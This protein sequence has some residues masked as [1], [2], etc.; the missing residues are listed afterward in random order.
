MPR[1]ERSTPLNQFD[2]FIYLFIH[3]F[4]GDSISLTLTKEPS[5]D[6]E[7][8]MKT[9][10]LSTIS[11]TADRTPNGVFVRINDVEWAKGVD[12]ELFTRESLTPLKP[13][14]DFV[15]GVRGGF[16]VVRDKPYYQFSIAAATDVST[17]YFYLDKTTFFYPSMVDLGGD[18]NVYDLLIL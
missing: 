2:L 9:E 14:I 7:K 1:G 10:S 5:D 17:Y 8:L 12:S 18:V 3:F 11:F 6:E 13:Q 4:F 15:L 16:D